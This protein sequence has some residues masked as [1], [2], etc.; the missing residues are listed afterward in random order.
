MA[1]PK[2]TFVV[3][4]LYESYAHSW[5]IH[6]GEELQAWDDL[7]DKERTAVVHGFRTF[8]DQFTAMYGVAVEAKAL[9]DTGYDGPFMGAV[10]VPLF[11]A[12]AKAEK[13]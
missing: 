3:R 7:S 8:V 13:V 4:D 6:T 10:T 12:I 5:L 9:R 1:F 11:Q 2:D